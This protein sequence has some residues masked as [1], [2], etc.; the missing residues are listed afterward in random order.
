MEIPLRIVINVECVITLLAKVM[1]HLFLLLN[2]YSMT[3]MAETVM[4]REFKFSIPQQEA[5]EALIA[6]AEQADLTLVF[7]DEVVHGKS[8]NALV[9]AFPRQKGIEL[10]LKCTGLVA[11][12]SKNVLII[13]MAEKSKKIKA[14]MKQSKISKFFMAA[15]ATS[16][17][18]GA[19]ASD[20]LVLEEVVVTAQ[21]RQ[22]SVQE[23]PLA[24]TSMSGD[25]LAQTGIDN[26]LDLQSMAPSLQISIAAGI[27]RVYIRGIGL[28]SFAMGGE[29][30]VAFHVDGAVIS[31]PSAQISSF[32]DVERIE[33]LRGPQG[34]LYGRNATGG[35]I[36]VHTR[37]P[38]EE[39][40]G[41][42]EF[43]AGDYNLLEF[44]GAV[45]GTLVDENILGRLALKTEKRDGFG[46]NLLDGNDLDDADSKSARLGFSYIGS[47]DFDAFLSL[48]HFE[49]DAAGDF[50]NLGQA[51]PLIT[52]PEIAMGG[53]IAPNI[54]DSNSEVDIGGDSEIDSATLELQWQLSDNISL[55]SLSNFFD[56]TRNAR[57]DLNGTPVQFFGNFQFE[58][59][60]HYSEEL[61]LTWDGDNH[62]SLFGLYYFEED[63]D[64]SITIEGPPPYT[65]ILNRP[66]I[67]FAGQLESESYAAFW[68][69]SWKLND[70][71]SITTGL[72]Y[73]KDTKQDTGSTTTPPGA[74][75]PIAREETWDDWTPTLGVEYTFSDDVL[76]YFKASEGYKTGVM[77]LGNA[78]PP[79]D[80]ETIVS[81]EAGIKSQ[82][83]DNRMQI[84][85][86]V[87]SSTIEDLQVQR[88]INGNL[89][90]VNA[91]EADIR[92]LEVESTVLLSDSL[93]LKL[94][95]AYLDTEFTDFIT[96]NTTFAP[97]VDVD[98]SGNPLP[99]A[100]ELQGD[101]SLE[102]K[103]YVG[104]HSIQSRVQAV[105]T[106]E[107][108]FNEF[109]EDISYQEATT[110]FNANVLLTS[111]DERW[112]L[113][114][115]GRNLS[116]EEIISHINI[117]SSAI[118]H[119]RA[120][121]LLSPRTYGATIG[122]NF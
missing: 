45:S 81:F 122:Y 12:F 121:T 36:N 111:S 40:E 19:A 120:A 96:Q 78:G 5:K 62:S 24:V 102:H 21:K 84:N 92:G 54:R 60:E 15:A 107:R 34:S 20:T 83:W 105:Y 87:F 55:K 26:I 69:T 100:P 13:S 58:S 43:T 95:A 37:R 76:L 88:P 64:A 7:P 4:E 108:W 71:W 89:I 27:P 11:V 68:N 97:N 119:A 16:S 17:A 117:T 86:A 47:D 109:Q 85:A 39:T 51:N 22:E 74:V 75:I 42:A 61:Q 1:R 18:C 53:Q 114:F 99:N 6:F 56:F 77:N 63:I 93:T 41:Y 49:S 110:T 82:W 3:L 115:W 94:N 30:S 52:P 9:G 73:S 116:D 65:E 50:H 106:D 2:F 14:N 10:M 23:I 113:N 8:A 48:T 29:P 98:L 31:R 104:E 118:G 25:D 46:E 59:S 57:T 66:F 32:F 35:S 90:T 38:T 44:E 80:P 70:L 79:V 72:R 112:T 103:L 67:R 33:V 101:L 91:A 28:T